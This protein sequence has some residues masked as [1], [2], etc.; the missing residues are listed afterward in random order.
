MTP[1]RT[2]Q[3]DTIDSIL[4]RQLGRNDEAITAAFWQLNRHAAALGP[5]FAA[6][7]QLELPA[8]PPR[9]VQQRVTLWQ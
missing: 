9:P 7:I 3:G 6:G 2:V 8:P 1:Y 5:V 4:W